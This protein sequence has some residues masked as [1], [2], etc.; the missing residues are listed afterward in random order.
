M[1]DKS[2]HYVTKSVTLETNMAKLISG[3]VSIK[4]FPTWKIEQFVNPVYKVHTAEISEAISY[5]QSRVLS[6]N[7]DTGVTRIKGL[8]LSRPIGNEIT[9]YEHI[10]DILKW[11]L[12]QYI[13]NSISRLIR[14]FSAGN[15]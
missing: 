5:W 3:R 1:S 6:Y 4:D 11:Q 8:E 12:I 2:R 7:C 10:E 9:S 15:Y 13:N 14:G